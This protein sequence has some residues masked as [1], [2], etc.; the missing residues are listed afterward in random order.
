[1]NFESKR[2]Q[3]IAQWIT[4]AFAFVVA[5]ITISN[6]LGLERTLFISVIIA[7]V[8]WIVANQIVQR[9]KPKESNAPGGYTI[10]CSKCSAAM[11]LHPPDSQ[12][13]MLVMNPC[14][15]GDSI[16]VKRRCSACKT[17]NTR[18]WD[19]LHPNVA[20]VRIK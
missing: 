8:G 9:A 16:E 15:R 19:N 14:D 18:Y 5:L 10:G 1:M 4:P 7:L 20:T 12:H 3:I 13:V 6:S 2:L 11:V 17:E